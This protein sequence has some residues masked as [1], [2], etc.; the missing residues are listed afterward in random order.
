MNVKE[1]ASL[2]SN[3]VASG[4]VLLQLVDN[5]SG[6]VVQEQ[7]AENMFWDGGIKAIARAIMK[8]FPIAYGINNLIPGAEIARYNIEDL[9]SSTYTTSYI[10]P[11]GRLILSSDDTEPEE[12]EDGYSKYNLASAVLR[13]PYGGTSPYVGTIN[14]AESLV[15][16]EGKNLVMKFVVDFP[17][18]AGNVTFRSVIIEPVY[19]YNSISVNSYSPEM[20]PL[21]SYYSFAPADGDYTTFNKNLLP[22]YSNSADY[23]NFIGRLSATKLIGRIGNVS[24]Y[25]LYYYN[26]ET[27][28]VETTTIQLADHTGAVLPA[29]CY[30]AVSEDGTKI[31]GHYV[32]SNVSYLVT[33]TIASLVNGVNNATIVHSLSDSHF[34]QTDAKLTWCDD[35]QYIY[36]A[37][38]ANN[39]IL[40]PVVNEPTQYFVYKLEKATGLIVSRMRKQGYDNVSYSFRAQSF[41]LL[42]KKNGKLYYCFAG[43]T[44]IINDRYAHPYSPTITNSPKILI[45]NL[46]NEDVE[47]GMADLYGFKASSSTYPRLWFN[48]LSQEIETFIGQAT[49]AVYNTQKLLYKLIEVPKLHRVLL[50]APVTKLNTQT[51]KLTYTVS[52]DLGSFFF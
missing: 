15:Y 2:K 39:S 6:Q 26:L 17:T 20:N 50:P 3:A 18:N 13:F 52:L 33:W 12:L 45:F 5:E 24:P 35:A 22:V 43:P 49:S 29:N 4:R 32:K 19:L 7:E 14:L 38:D 34:R 40:D 10:F 9:G 46:D 51:M 37:G 25:Y 23:V 47:G 30:L 21:F 1:R 44:A 42:F 16:F 8:H 31:R 28:L 11:W 36:F 27:N 41:N 48:H